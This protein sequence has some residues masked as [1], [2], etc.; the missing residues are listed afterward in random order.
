M[1]PPGW[2]LIQSD[3]CPYEI[4]RRDLGDTPGSPVPEK[5]PREDT[6]RKQPSANQEAASEK[7]ALPIP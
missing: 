2:T 3:Q 7:P 1:R 6:G 4:N 5:R